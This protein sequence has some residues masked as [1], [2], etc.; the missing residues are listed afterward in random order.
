MGSVPHPDCTVVSRLLY[1]YD[2]LSHWHCW[3]L[4]ISP[5]FFYLGLCT[6]MLEFLSARAENEAVIF[7]VNCRWYKFSEIVIC[8]Q[9]VSLN[10]KMR[11]NIFWI[12]TVITA[13]LNFFIGGVCVWCLD[14]VSREK[15]KRSF[16]VSI[17]LECWWHLDLESFHFWWVAIKLCI[18]Y[19]HCYPL[20]TPTSKTNYCAKCFISNFGHT[21]NVI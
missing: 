8:L 12:L 11:T 19:A 21:F 5:F 18:F 2:S 10:I 7:L 15:K 1:E 13:K 6:T 9:K 3:L 16:G 20:R 14:G 17:R 4:L